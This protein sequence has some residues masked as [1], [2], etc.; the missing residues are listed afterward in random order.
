MR[1]LRLRFDDS[2]V[3]CS[4]LAKESR[5]V[6]PSVRLGLLAALGLTFAFVAIDALVAEHRLLQA[7]SIHAAHMV[8]IVGLVWATYRPWWLSVQRTGLTAIVV[9]TAWTWSLMSVVGGFPT[10][11]MALA[12]PLLMVW[13][14]TLFRVGPLRTGIGSL[15]MLPAL[16]ATFAAM[17]ASTETWVLTFA[18]LANFYSLALLTAYLLERGSRRAFLQQRMIR[19]FAP[20][21]VADAIE[22]GQA[23]LIE[24]PHRRRV[25]VLF[26]DVVGFTQTADSLDPESLAQIVQEYLATMA[27]IIENHGGTLNEFAGDGVM[28]IFGAPAELAPE[29][30]VAAAVAAAGEIQASLPV[31]NERW[32][33]IGLD[34]ELRTRVGINTG[35]VSVGTFGSGGRAT[36]T[37]IGLQTN[38]AA[39][40]Q[41]ECEPGEILLSQASWHLVKDRVPCEER[42]EAMVKGVHFPVKLYAP[43]GAMRGT[44]GS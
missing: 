26:S 30:Q 39:R 2:D 16:A 4:F 13:L 10:L 6:L 24:V 44:S 5:D 29:D 23:E 25:T 31:L 34:H 43:L 9:G 12:V 20:P 33:R 15:F 27:T 32:F 19:R 22:T 38:I 7:E 41:A 36:Y 28:A 17:D 42:G 3:E 8:T 1:R 14:A 37:G 11:Y 35:F 18:Y 40:I 21:S